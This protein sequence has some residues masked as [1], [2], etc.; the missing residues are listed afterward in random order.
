MRPRKDAASTAVKVAVRPGHSTETIIPGTRWTSVEK[1]NNSAFGSLYPTSKP[2]KG[3]SR[4][5][6]QVRLSL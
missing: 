1:P 3:T 5:K 4:G 6:L 2:C